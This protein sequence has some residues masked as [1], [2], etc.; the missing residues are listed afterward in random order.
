MPGH[1][2]PPPGYALIERVEALSLAEQYFPEG[3][4]TLAQYLGVEIE[5][6][7]LG[8]FAG[9]CLQ[10]PQT[11]ICIN[12]ADCVARQRFTLAHELAHLILGTSPDLQQSNVAPFSS[13]ESEEREANRLA[14]ELLLPLAK[15]RPLVPAPPLDAKAIAQV[16]RIAGVTETMAACHVAGC[17]EDLGLVNAAVFAYQE[18]RVRWIWSPCFEWSNEQAMWLLNKVRTRTEEVYR[19][20]DGEDEVI[21]AFSLKGTQQ[22]TLFVQRLPT[23]T[24]LKRSPDERRKRLFADDLSF[25]ASVN[26]C[27]GSF[28][29]EAQ[30]MKLNDALVSFN[31]RYH[32]RWTGERGVRINSR[33]GQRFLRDRLSAWCVT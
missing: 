29:V 5:R 33:E 17:A 21:T 20:R 25:Q 23:D 4:E 27:L 30:G 32:D 9:W 19:C 7:V 31:E 14:G 2:P 26:G 28:K 10:G 8:S 22:A 12:S 6:G 18:N 1:S 3:P 11:I 16:A 15:L 24:A 13:D